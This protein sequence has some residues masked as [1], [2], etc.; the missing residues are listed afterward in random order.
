[1][2][3]LAILALAALTPACSDNE[4]DSL[5]WENE[6]TI[7]ELT[8]QLKLEKLRLELSP[9]PPAT[10]HPTQHHLHPAAIRSD[11][12]LLTSHKASLESE[13]NQLSHGWDNFRRHILM[14]K[15]A[16]LSGTSLAQYNPGNSKTYQNVTIT[17][18]DDSG[19]AIKHSEGTARLRYTDLTPEEQ[20]HFGLDAEFSRQAL[21]AER[22]QRIAYE[23]SMQK[24]MAAKETERLATAQIQK[25]QEEK[26]RNQRPLVSVNTRPPRVSPLASSFGR[27]GETRRLSSSSRYYS[28]YGQSRRSRFYHH[29]TPVQVPTL[30][31]TSPFGIDS[32]PPFTPQTSS[33]TSIFD[34]IR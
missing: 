19:V 17:S 2:R 27:L 10:S 5:S 24:A 12:R 18:I 25:R 31:S 26:L 9:Q 14:E 33:Q 21:T 15:R 3:L 7:I 4:Q 32:R 13:I 16:S 20:S 28:N 34:I 6:K 1:M 8:N 11:I 22:Q 29:Y 30:P 23:K